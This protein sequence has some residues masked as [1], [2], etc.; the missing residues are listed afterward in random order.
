MLWPE[1][2]TSKSEYIAL[3]Q[4]HVFGNRFREWSSIDALLE[5]DY[6]GAVSIRYRVADGRFMK[7]YVPRADIEATVAGFEALGADRAL[8]WANE[9]A[10]DDALVIQGELMFSTLGLYLFGSRAKLPMRKALADITQSFHYFGLRT[11]FALK[12]A[13]TPSSY[14]DLMAILELWPDAMIEFST[15]AN[16]VGTI[17]GRN[18]IV[19]EVRHY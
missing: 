2:I 10:P 16:N 9:S 19:W 1:R 15:F 7:Y 14:S 11:V 6:S 3:T 13:L 12:G 17:P 4:K 5:S 8:M 18:T